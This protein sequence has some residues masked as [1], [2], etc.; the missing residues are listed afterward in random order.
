MRTKLP[1]DSTSSMQAI[2]FQ[3]YVALEKCFDLLKGEKL[4]IELYGDVSVSHNSQIEVKNYKENLTDTHENIWK[5]LK[6]WLDPSFD[7]SH[8]K[9]LILL[10]TQVLGV[11][12]S[13]TNWNSKTSIEKRNILET[14]FAAYTSTGKQNKRELM[15]FVLN[16]ENS[17]KLNFVLEKFSITTSHLNNRDYYNEIK[18]K[19]GKG[20]LKEK[21]DDFINSLLGFIITPDVI[22]HTS[23]EITFDNFTARVLSCTEEYCSKT[24]IFPQKI[25]LQVDD[26]YYLEHLFVKKIKDIEHYD[27]IQQAISDYVQTINM[28]QGELK[29]HSVPKS[30]YEKYN[31]ELIDF[32]KREYRTALRKCSSVNTIEDSKDFYDRITSIQHVQPFSNF[33]DTPGYFRNGMIH[34]IVNDEKENIKW[35]LENEQSN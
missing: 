1:N 13:L 2:V 11:K 5:T 15:S 4:Y 19:K 22:S 10:T 29:T 25:S 34:D 35:K 30:A 7:P 3:F 21:R 9:S 6:N 33:N 24:K 17:M 20:V 12:S 31:E 28:I 8:Y 26:T 23:W 27:E 32:H 18:E 16:E 14:I